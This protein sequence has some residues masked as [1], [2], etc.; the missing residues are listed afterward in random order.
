MSKR[1]SCL[2][3]SLDG[4]RKC[5][6]C[7]CCEPTVVEFKCPFNG[8]DL[9]PKS[10]FLLESVGGM[11][12]ATG[13]LTLKPSHRHYFQVRTE[14]A[15]AGL[16]SCDF[17]IYTNKGIL[18]VQIDFDKQFWEGVITKVAA[19]YENQIIPALLLQLSIQL[20]HNLH[21]HLR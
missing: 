6:C 20:H 2:G 11:C 21:Y 7:V 3:A 14:M 4:I 9:D 19:F 5:K 10:A 15:V 12:N 8:K 16:P 13:K 18:V 1:Y 17:V